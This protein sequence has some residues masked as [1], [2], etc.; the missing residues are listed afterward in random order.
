MN[1]GYVIPATYTQKQS[2]DR[3]S[4]PQ[5]GPDANQTNVWALK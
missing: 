3:T 4:T 2:A 5:V 1:H